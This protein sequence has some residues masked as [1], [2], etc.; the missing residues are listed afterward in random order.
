M[1]SCVV[2]SEQVSPSTATTVS[3]HNGPTSFRDNTESL[4]MVF[5]LTLLVNQ[6]WATFLGRGPH[7]NYLKECLL[8]CFDNLEFSK[9]G[10]LFFTI[11]CAITRLAFVAASGAADKFANIF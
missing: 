5:A 9:N 6:R 7:D 3:H 11:L 2:A 8:F 4:V 10:L 1:C